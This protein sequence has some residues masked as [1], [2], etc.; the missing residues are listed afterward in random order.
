MIEVV[1]YETPNCRPCKLVGFML[2]RIAEQ[3]K[4]KP[5]TFSVVNAADDFEKVR[6][7][8]ITAAPTV[9]VSKDGHEVHRFVGALFKQEDYLSYIE[10]L[11]QP[12]AEPPTPV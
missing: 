2:D 7:M 12:S 9:V 5:V 10:S 6:A 11:L 8:G 1:K 4:D 3:L